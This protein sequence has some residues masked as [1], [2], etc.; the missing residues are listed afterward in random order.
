MHGKKQI[1]SEDLLRDLNSPQLEAVL[2]LGSPLMVLAGAGSGKT[3]VI[4]YRIAHLLSEKKV[5]PWNILAVTFTNK[6]AQEMRERV[7]DLIGRQDGDLWVSTFHSACARILRGHAHLLSYSQDFS[8]FDERDQLGVMNACLHDLDL[9]PKRFPPLMFLRRIRTAKQNFQSPEGLPSEGEEDYLEER[10]A[11]VYALYQERLRQAQA[12]DFDDL[13]YQ[14]LYLYESHPEVL[15]YYRSRWLH[16]L[17]DE[18]QDTN[19]IQYRLV[20]TLS[21]E[22]RN[23]CVVGDDDQSIYSW[24]GADLGNI[25]HFE[26]DFPDTRV[27]R[28]EQNYRSTQRILEA[29]GAVIQK[30]HFRREKSIWTENE[31]GEPPSFYQA[32]NER[33]EAVFVADEIQHLLSKEAFHARDMAVFYRT[34]A[35]SRVL[36]EELVSRQISFSIFGGLGF[37]ERKEIKDVVAYL[38]ALLH[39]GDDTSW[40]RI[41]NVPKRGIGKATLEAADALCSQDGIPLSEA[42]RRFSV[43]GSGAPARRIRAFLEVMDALAN[44]VPTSGTSELVHAVLHETGYWDELLK[45]TE[46]RAQERMENIQELIN[47]VGEIEAESEDEALSEFLE[48]VALVSDVDRIDLRED[49]VSLMTLHAAK[50]LEFPVVFIMGLEEGIMP[51]SL[52]LEDSSEVEEERR[53]CYVGMTRAQRRLYLSCALSRRIWGSMRELEPSRF[54]WE[55]P[56]ECLQFCSP[57]IMNSGATSYQDAPSPGLYE[58]RWVRHQAFGVGTVRRVEENGSRVVINFP[59]I[60]EKRFLVDL[61]PLEWL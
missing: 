6:A 58:G 43:T 26:K 57:A 15:D 24:R 44:R 33:D 46:R 61:A 14:T 53:L 59:G 8:I 52:S 32:V 49:Q 5:R 4:T 45:Q 3:R 18:F 34:H 28:L 16:V 21:Q 1:N 35:Q 42:L 30:N 50:G 51:H 19:H 11:R 36:E 22:H 23:L 10:V 9:D 47:L 2:Y 25:L 60:G 29:S 56:R 38:R 27:I 31:A 20:K 17:V 37:Y 39:P 40:R 12:M 54:L 13:L 48:R 55:I 7:W 41:L